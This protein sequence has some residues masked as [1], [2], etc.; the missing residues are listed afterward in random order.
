MHVAQ[1]TGGFPVLDAV[2]TM[3][4]LGHDTAYYTMWAT[5]WSVVAIAA[6]GAVAVWAVM[7]GNRDKRRDRSIALLRLVQS[8]RFRTL[9]LELQPFADLDLSRAYH[10]DSWH[11][12][13]TLNYAATATRTTAATLAP[14]PSGEYAQRMIE[15]ANVYEEMY[16]HI[17]Y[18][19]VDEKVLLDAVSLLLLSFFY[20]VQPILADVEDYAHLNFGNLRWFARQAQQWVRKHE[21][22]SDPRLLTVDASDRKHT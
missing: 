7:N 15:V 5:W 11:K 18:K 1:T 13:Q 22:R 17:K 21:P 20:Y 9:T 4:C 8:D 10:S 6:T 12:R 2:R 3:L 16:L 14:M 19:L